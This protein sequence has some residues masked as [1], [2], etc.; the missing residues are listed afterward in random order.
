M[1]QSMRRSSLNV[2]KKVNI[3]TDLMKTV[4]RV[5][6]ITVASPGCLLNVE[7]DSEKAT[8]VKSTEDSSHTEE[9]ANDV[10]PKDGVA[11]L[12]DAAAKKVLSD[13]NLLVNLQ[14][15]ERLVQQNLYHKAQLLYRDVPSAEKIDEVHAIVPDNHVLEMNENISSTLQED[16]LLPESEISAGGSGF[17]VDEEEETKLELLWSFECELTDERNV[18][19]LAW[20]KCNSDLLVVGYGDFR[21]GK[22]NNM[23]LLLF[24]S[25]KNPNFPERVIETHSGVTAVCF[26]K[27]HPSLLAVGMYDGTVAIYDMKLDQSKPVVRNL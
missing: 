13:P 17:V 15:A 4:E 18:T 12:A 21:F 27:L 26:S 11:V 2:D 14:R 10:T 20:N 7:E 24:W 25:L 6:A 5:V 19:C 8:A 22:G 1:F 23:G 16:G 3:K 9:K